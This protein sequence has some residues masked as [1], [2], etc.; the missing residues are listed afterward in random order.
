MIGVAILPE[1]KRKEK[2]RTSLKELLTKLFAS[3]ILPF[4]RDAAIVYGA[5]VGAARAA[6]K[7]ISMPDGQIGSIAS[8]HGFAV[9]T[10]DTEPFIALNIPV[11]NPWKL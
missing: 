7:T 5:I 4:D 1:G 2:I 3:R 9:A 11:I 10:R 6:G 8:V